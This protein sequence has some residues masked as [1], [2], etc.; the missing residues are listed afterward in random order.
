MSDMHTGMRQDP[1]GQ[2]P[3]ETRAEPRTDAG[4]YGW[5]GKVPCVGDFIRSGLSPQFISAWDP[6]MQR[7]MVTAREVLGDRW[8]D[9]YLGAPIWRFAL[10]A[11]HCGPQ[12]VAGVVMP[13]VDRVGRQFPLC[14]A[15]ETE[16][17]P[18]QV[19]RAL[20]PVF[21]DL[22]AIALSM[23]DDDA[24]L[25]AL[26]A[27]LAALPAPVVSQDGPEMSR[28]GLATA[29]VAPVGEPEATLA[30]M[31]TE[32]PATLWL[33]SVGAHDLVLLCPHMPDGPGE[34]VALFDL[35]APA[36]ANVQGS[37]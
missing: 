35:Q 33:A 9:C 36:W 31:A 28:A 12:A 4:G 21:E 26:Q 34:A 17:Q 19:F 10:P 23:L 37:L 27:A 1:A 8:Y 5:Y 20:E 18:W 14:L 32:A 11:G 25:G 7:L 6:W 16:G 2:A 24:S 30:L 29:R 15:V 3:S 22:E 13:S